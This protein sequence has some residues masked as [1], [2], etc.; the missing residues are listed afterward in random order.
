M[1]GLDPS[2]PRQCAGRCR[3][4]NVVFQWT[5]GYK[6][7]L[8]QAHCYYC[9]RPLDRTAVRMLSPDVP[10]ERFYEPRFTHEGD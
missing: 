9:D 2:P 4:C 5:A 1:V 7:L 6:R 10:V 8:R 3:P